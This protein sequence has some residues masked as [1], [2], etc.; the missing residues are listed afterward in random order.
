MNRQFKTSKKK[1]DRYIYYDSYGNKVAEIKPGENDVTE[2]FISTLHE[3]DDDSVDSD[4]REVYKAPYHLDAFCFDD[5]SGSDDRNGWLADESGNP[6]TILIENE[7]EF[8]YDRKIARTK[9][10]VDSLSPEQKQLYDDLYDQELSGREVARREG[11]VEGTIR[12]RKNKL[13]DGLRE[14]F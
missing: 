8:E 2:A 6:E 12:K 10:L 11:V 14:N 5:E 1:R 4:R 9:E 7:E 3:M 13:L